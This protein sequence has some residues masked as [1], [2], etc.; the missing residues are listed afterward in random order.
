MSGSSLPFVEW[1]PRSQKFRV[2]QDAA[3]YLD[4]LDEKIGAFHFVAKP[5]TK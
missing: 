3:K 4:Q 1:D 2:N 5:G